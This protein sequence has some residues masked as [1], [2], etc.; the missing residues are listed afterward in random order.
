[1]WREEKSFFGVLSQD[2]EHSKEIITVG[3]AVMILHRKML[4]SVQNYRC[5]FMNN[6]LGLFYG[7]N[8]C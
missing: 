6:N 7:I 8:I 4:G 3:V 2:L 1:M 5:V